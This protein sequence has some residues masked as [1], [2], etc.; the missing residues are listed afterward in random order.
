MD[1]KCSKFES[2]F[3]F[4][5]DKLIEHSKECEDCKKELE[6][7]NKVSDIIS[8]VKWHYIKQRKQKILGLKIACIFSL[9]LLS[10][11]TISSLYDNEDMLETLRY[12]DCL[13]AEELGF[14]VDSYG[15]VMVDE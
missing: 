3:I 10:S 7:M 13:T 8:E 14:P 11:L 4:D 2:L 15:L 1:N 5:E 6:T 9:L 12:G